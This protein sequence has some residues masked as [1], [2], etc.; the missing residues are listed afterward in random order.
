MTDGR[1]T[2]R[3]RRKGQTGKG[4]FKLNKRRRQKGERKMTTEKDRRR[5]NGGWKKENDKNIIS[6]KETVFIVQ[7]HTH[8][9]ARTHARTHRCHRAL[10]C[11]YKLCANQPIGSLFILNN[12][13]RTTE[14][15]T[16]LIDTA[17]MK[18]ETL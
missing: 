17:V 8:T 6:A 10:T 16:M 4:F 15:T 14:Q 12:T 7:T 18:H 9:Q 11:Q 13:V 2:G 3:E 1:K 5:N